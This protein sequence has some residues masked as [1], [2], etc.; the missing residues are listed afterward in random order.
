MV[1]PRK[2]KND[3]CTL[4]GAEIR[5]LTAE[6]SEAEVWMTKSRDNFCKMEAGRES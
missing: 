2:P 4:A 6:S 3:V 5:E 1:S